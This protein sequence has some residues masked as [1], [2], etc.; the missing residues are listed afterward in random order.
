[1]IFFYYKQHQETIELTILIIYE[2]E[3]CRNESM[4]HEPEVQV[5]PPILGFP[6]NFD[7]YF[8]KL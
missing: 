4:E 5:F 6:L 7:K 3:V 2:V 8:F 1:M